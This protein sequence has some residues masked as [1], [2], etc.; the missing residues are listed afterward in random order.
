MGAREGV[1]REGILCGRHT[2][3]R[4]VGLMRI[5]FFNN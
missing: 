5:V 2:S 1:P 4:V 3:I